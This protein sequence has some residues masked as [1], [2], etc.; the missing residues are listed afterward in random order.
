MYETAQSILTEIHELGYE[1]YIVGGYPRDL[2]CGK[3]TGDIDI[4]TSMLPDCIAE[5]FKV[6]ESHKQY[7]SFVIE[8][9]EMI[10]EITTYR[11]DFYESNRYPKIDFVSTL[12]EDLQRRDFIINTL[13]IDKK[14]VFIDLLG[15]REDIDKKIIR[16]I[17]N[18]DKKIKEDPLR[19][20][21]AIRFAIYLNFQL[22]SN[23]KKAIQ[24]HKMLLKTLSISRVQKELKKIHDL[25]Q[26]NN[27]I[28]ALDLQLYLP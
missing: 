16:T 14:G 5:K 28:K 19:I 7:G 8:K 21:R 11:S 3:E 6:V 24:D 26:W 10:F 18:A 13:C 1:A 17:G 25:E 27:W 9:N 12:Q 22:D 20:I 15:A 23:L 2:Y 4:C